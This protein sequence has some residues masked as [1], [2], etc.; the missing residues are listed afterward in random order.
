MVATTI[1]GDAEPAPWIAKWKA[2][3]EDQ[4]R[5]IY[6]TLVDREDLHDRLGEIACPTLVIHGTADAAIPLAKATALCDGLPR[7]RGV[8]PIDGGGHAVN[9][10]H[11]GPVTAAL[12]DF[13]GGLWGGRPPGNAASGPGK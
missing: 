8:I 4:V 6:A 3:P 2:R 12:R 13:L 5:H 7:C 10:T 11:P 1:L 9:L